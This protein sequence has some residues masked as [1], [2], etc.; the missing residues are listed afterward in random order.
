MSRPLR[1]EF[2]GAYY[3]VMNRGAGRRSIFA[4][5]AHRLLFL[6]LLREAAEMLRAQ[7]HAYC[8]MDNHYHLLLSTPDGNLNRIMRHLNGVY[9]QRSNRLKRTAGPLFR[10]RY[11]AI[12][13]EADAYLLCVSRYIHLN[14]VAAAMVKKAQH[15]PWSSYSAYIGKLN[16]P[17]WLNTTVTLGLMGRRSGRQRYRRFVEDGVDPETQR[18]YDTKKQSPIFGRA[19]FVKKIEKRI[20]THREVPEHRQIRPPISLAQLVTHTAEVF[21]TDKTKIVQAKR[22]RGDY[23]AARGAAMYLSRKIAGYPLMAIADYFGLSSYGSASGQI[24]RFQ[25]RLDNDKN[26]KKLVARIEQ[27]LR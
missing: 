1:I 21:H 5:D 12:L 15:Y 26:I 7:I 2:K 8:L 25:Q 3:H 23:H 20:K 9:T 6:E 16:P 22:G 27:K 14:P 24:H 18:F 10:G 13:V 11:Q 19:G 4:R 17:L